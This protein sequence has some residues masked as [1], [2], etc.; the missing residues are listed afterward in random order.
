MSDTI[1]DQRHAHVPSVRFPIQVNMLA[2]SSE[3]L[4]GKKPKVRKTRS[5]NVRSNPDPSSSI[6]GV[7][8]PTQ[9]KRHKEKKWKGT[10]GKKES[11]Y[12]SAN[13][14]V[15]EEGLLLCSWVGESPTPAGLSLMA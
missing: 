3:D 5:P 14:S 7:S 12:L 11:T 6:F 13:E 15:T 10:K 2:S 8:F 1:P 9:K 4:R